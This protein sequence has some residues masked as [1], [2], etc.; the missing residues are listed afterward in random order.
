M[1]ALIQTSKYMLEE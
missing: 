1:L